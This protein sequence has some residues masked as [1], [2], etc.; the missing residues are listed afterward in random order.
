MATLDHISEFYASGRAHGLDPLLSGTGLAEAA[1]VCGFIAGCTS[2]SAALG[3]TGCGGSSALLHGRGT[4]HGPG[5]LFYSLPS[6]S[7]MGYRAV[8]AASPPSLS[9]SFPRSSD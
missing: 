6:L 9:C 3:T 7:Y 1:S 4:G 8:N 2:D 5:L